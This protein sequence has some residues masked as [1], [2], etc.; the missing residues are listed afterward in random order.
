[1]INFFDPNLGWSGHY[2]DAKIT[3][4]GLDSFTLNGNSMGMPKS[5]SVQLAFNTPPTHLRTYGGPL[6]WRPLV[7]NLGT[8]YPSNFP[9]Y[10]N[11]LEIPTAPGSMSFSGG[12]LTLQL[13]DGVSNLVSTYKIK[14]PG[15]TS[16]PVPGL[17]VYRKFGVVNLNRE[18]STDPI[19]DRFEKRIVQNGNL[20]FSA[21]IDP[22]DVVMS[23]V[24]SKASGDY[25]LLARTDVPDSAFVPHPSSGSPQGFG[26]DAPVKD[27]DGSVR[28]TLY[29]PAQQLKRKP[30]VPATVQGAF[31]GATSNTPGTGTMGLGAFWTAPLLTNQTK[32]PSIRQRPKLRTSTRTTENKPSARRSSPPI[33]RCHHP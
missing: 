4:S 18:A 31:V 33:A 29:D 22:K 32:E 25:R 24:P 12:A 16:L 3:V 17:P 15:S 20:Y 2:P 26:F 9:L 27:F 14:F 21:M 5:G 10:S 1:M 23:V 28:G 7:R 8:A 6:D 19:E 13:F 30:F 11:I